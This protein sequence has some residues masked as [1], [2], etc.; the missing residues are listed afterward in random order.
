MNSIDLT[1]NPPIL[2]TLNEVRTSMTDAVRDQWI[3]L[4]VDIRARIEARNAK[5]HRAN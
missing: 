2:P 5:P 4:E 1:P 3:A